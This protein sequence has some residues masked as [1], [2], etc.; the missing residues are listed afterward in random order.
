MIDAMSNVL[1]NVDDHLMREANIPMAYWRNL[2]KTAHIKNNE[3]IKQYFDEKVKYGNVL[4]PNLFIHSFDNTFAERVLTKA[5]V[6][7]VARKFTVYCLSSAYL[8]E[9]I[10][11]RNL[12]LGDHEN[13][14]ESITHVKVLALYGLGSEP[15]NDFGKAKNALLK[16]MERRFFNG[17]PTLFSSTMTQKELISSESYSPHCLNRI[18][19]NC[20]VASVSN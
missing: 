20:V 9:S 2:P 13:G 8:A 15:E 6:G 19:N 5:V 14:W 7:F 3:P 16:V 18:F 12:Y 4:I 17:L 1:I 11:D 10:E